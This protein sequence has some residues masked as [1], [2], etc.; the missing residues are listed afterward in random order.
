[1]IGATRSIF[2]G[3]TMIEGGCI[4]F[5]LSLS[6]IFFILFFYLDKFD[7]GSRDPHDSQYPDYLATLSA[8]TISCQRLIKTKRTIL[9]DDE[10]GRIY[11][12]I[13]LKTEALT[14]KRTW[15]ARHVGQGLSLKLEGLL[16]TWIL[17]MRKKHSS[18]GGNNK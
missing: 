2:R 10:R 8:T 6:F 9:M 1:M 5:S 4:H 15:T 13:V 3:D 14:E 12:L 17:Y 16:Q 18:G 7:G 11:N